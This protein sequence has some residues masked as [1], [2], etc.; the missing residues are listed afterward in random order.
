MQNATLT[1]LANYDFLKQL[2]DCSFIEKII[3]FGSRARGDN[4]ERSDIDLAIVCPKATDQDWRQV[5]DITENADT[6]LKID[7]VRFNT[8]SDIS[9]LK[10]NIIKE[11]K[12]IYAKI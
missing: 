11:G 5:L 10:K 7:C 12:V 4:Q 8:L 1:P 2:T 9:E 3:L 6:L